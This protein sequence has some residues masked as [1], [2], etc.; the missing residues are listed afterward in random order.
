MEDLMATPTTTS[1]TKKR[2]EYAKSPQR[3]MEI[4]AAAVEVFSEYGFRDGSLRS[5]ADRAGITHAGIRHHFPTKVGLLEAVLHWR[6]EDALERAKRGNLQGL[7]VIRAWI[8]SVEENT[9]RPGLV[10]LEI[11]LGAEATAS[12]HPAHDYF[13]D[14]YRRAEELL[15]R[16][17][18]TAAERGELRDGMDPKFTARML[19]SV[20]LGLQS[21]WLRNRAIDLAWDLERTIQA[22]LTVDLRTAPRP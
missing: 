15:G 2:G 12:D 17:F 13:E 18:A 20:T 21:L 9:R 5:V 1:G 19:L 14:L 22:V 7:Q 4:I 6:E 10:E 8:D 16:A 11:V 3:R